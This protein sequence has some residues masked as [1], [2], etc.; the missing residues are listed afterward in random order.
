MSYHNLNVQNLL[1]TLRRKGDL[2]IESSIKNYIF[3]R[4]KMNKDA[5]K[6]LAAMKK[7]DSKAGASPLSDQDH[8]LSTVIRVLRQVNSISI[9][10]L[11]SLLLFLS[12]PFLK[13]KPSGWSLIPKY[14]H[15]GV[16]Y[17]EEKHD[18]VK[19]LENIDLVLSTLS[20]GRADL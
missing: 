6:L 16:V 3:S 10:I 9:P 8:Q 13:S 2:C 7:M 14:M 19:E 4:K 18:N 17:C 20:N 11:E 1:S 5:K 12:T 15:K